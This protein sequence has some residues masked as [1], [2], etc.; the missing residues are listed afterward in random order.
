MENTHE[1]LP[2]SCQRL[3]LMHLIVVICRYSIH[4]PSYFTLPTLPHIATHLQARPFIQP[5]YHLVIY[6]C[7]D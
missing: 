1:M 2:L 6:N 5:R 7:R 3:A 4:L